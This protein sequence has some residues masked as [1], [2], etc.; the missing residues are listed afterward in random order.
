MKGDRMEPS[1]AMEL[2]RPVPSDRTLVGYTCAGHVTAFK[3][4]ALMQSMPNMP[5]PGKLYKV[6]VN[7]N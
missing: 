7:Q 3:S 6:R 4:D 5:E 2:A 1:R